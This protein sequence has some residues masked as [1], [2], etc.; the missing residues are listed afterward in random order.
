MPDIT[1]ADAF[2]GPGGMAAYETRTST[3]FYWLKLHTAGLH[4][5]GRYRL[6]LRMSAHDNLPTLSAS[7]RVSSGPRAG[8]VL[9]SPLQGQAVDTMFRLVATDWEDSDIP[10]S[11][12]FWRRV[13]G[14]G[15]E[16][17]TAGLQQNDTLISDWSQTNSITTPLPEGSWMIL[18][19]ARDA[20]GAESALTL[21]SK[22]VTVTKYSLSTT[23]TAALF[24]ELASATS[25]PQ[26]LVGAVSALVSTSNFSLN[27]PAEIADAAVMC[28]Q[29]AQ[30]KTL[31]AGSRPSAVAQVSMLKKIAE[32]AALGTSKS[33]IAIGT[34]VAAVGV[35]KWSLEHWLNATD[36]AAM[37]GMS[38]D[39]AEQFVACASNIAVVQKP[40]YLSNTTIAESDPTDGNSLEH[41][42]RLVGYEFAR[43]ALAVQPFVGELARIQSPQLAVGA[44]VINSLVASTTTTPLPLNPSVQD[45]MNL[46][47]AI[48]AQQ[49]EIDISDVGKFR[50]PASSL[51]NVTSDM[52]AMGYDASTT[53]SI[54][55]VQQWRGGN[56]FG[57]SASDSFS[58]EGNVVSLELRSSAGPAATIEG[59]EDPIFLWLPI[60]SDICTLQGTSSDWHASSM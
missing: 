9:V 42:A 52:Q 41:V 29:S 47:D 8:N 38:A 45:L 15:A 55:S 36:A 28:L 48:K 34:R 12:A 2:S 35:L 56:P 33:S 18:N 4:I 1:Q 17:P 19:R 37:V 54:L 11:F 23:Q 7:F 5:D 24:K 40:G 10:L 46:E 49:V 51:A 13:S 53:T 3:S 31:V 20:T 22:N 44:F 25:S 43:R 6:S 50:I 21:V 26:Q 32:T 57:P 14:P 59:L 16:T 58:V 60:W 30:Q 27:M 39:D